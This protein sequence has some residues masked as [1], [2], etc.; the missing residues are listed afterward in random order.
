MSVLE[1]KFGIEEIEAENYLIEPGIYDFHVI[2]V[3]K[4]TTRK[5][6]PNLIW[7]LR[8]KTRDDKHETISYHTPLPWESPKGKMD[9]S[10]IG[11]LLQMFKG[12]GVS[13]NGVGLPHLG[14]FLAKT[15]QLEITIKRGPHWRTGQ[16]VAIYEAKMIENPNGNLLG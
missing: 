12:L 7:Q 8:I 3:K 6:R 15:G 14:L 5:G 13:W 10:D 4:R 9:I 11:F 1:F 16:M 2:D